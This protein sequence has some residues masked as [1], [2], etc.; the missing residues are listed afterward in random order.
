MQTGIE[1]FDYYAKKESAKKHNASGAK[2]KRGVAFA[3]FSYATGVYPFSLEI[4]GCRLT[5]NQDGSVKMM[6]GA[7]EIGQGSDTVLSQMA[8]EAMGI[9]VDRIYADAKT[10]TD[11]SPFDPASYASR[12]TYVAGLA[13]KLAGEEL[14]SKILKAAADFYGAGEYDLVD[15]FIINLANGEKVERLSE[16]A[17]K[18]YYDIPKAGCL[19]AEVSVNRHDNAYPCGI[20]FA[21]IEADTGT[22]EVKVLSMLNV[23]DSGVIIN[24]LLAEGQVEGGMGMGVPYALAEELIYDK[25]TGRPLNNNLLDYKMPTMMDVPDFDCAFVEPHDPTAPYGNKGL[26][27]PPLCSPA[28]AIRNAVV[29]ALGVIL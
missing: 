27:E 22:G 17:L 6:V 11:Y 21:E 14:R 15:G 3:A 20:T 13:A 29:D 19:T 5:L 8:A 25:K 28:G 7:S 24:P 23:H 26:G 1:R 4:G 16:L 2:T 10:D 12:Q 18:S 9:S